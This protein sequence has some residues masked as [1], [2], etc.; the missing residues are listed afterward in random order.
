MLMRGCSSVFPPTLVKGE[1]KNKRQMHDMGEAEAP[2]DP[3]LAV[4]PQPLPGARSL[5]AGGTFDVEAQGFCFLPWDEMLHWQEI[6]LCS[7]T[8]QGGSGA[9]GGFRPPV[10]AGV[11]LG[12]S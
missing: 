8:L 6:L 11:L 4:A 9:S 5:W 7:P 2:A 12:S 3:C 1:G 10:A